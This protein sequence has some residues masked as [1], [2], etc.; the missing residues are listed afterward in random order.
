[1]KCLILT[2]TF[3]LMFACN[4]SKVKEDLAKIQTDLE[5]LKQDH[6]KL[7]DDHNQLVKD[8]VKAELKAEDALEGSKMD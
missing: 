3:G 5:Q 6:A 1:M 4:D 8:A 7:R 2:I